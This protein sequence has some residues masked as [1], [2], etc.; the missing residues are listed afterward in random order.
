V[1]ANAVFDRRRRDILAL[2]GLED[3]LDASGEAQVAF[4]VLLALDR[5]SVV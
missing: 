2:A 3:F 4:G 5:K 1:L